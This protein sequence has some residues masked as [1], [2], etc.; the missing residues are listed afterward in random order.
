[1]GNRSEF[2]SERNYL[3]QNWYFSCISCQIN[4]TLF[5]HLGKYLSTMC[6]LSLFIFSDRDEGWIELI[7][8]I[9]ET[10]KKDLEI[11]SEFST[12]TVLNN[13]IAK[14]IGAFHS[15]DGYETFIMT[16]LDEKRNQYAF[17][18]NVTKLMEPT[19]NI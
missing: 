6:D 18:R 13:K 16:H 3:L 14:K 19:A 1:M 9:E 11:I 4:S 15:I 8:N 7:E 5:I 17:I 12:D 10:L 2:H